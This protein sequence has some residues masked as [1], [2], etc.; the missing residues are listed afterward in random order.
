MVEVEVWLWWGGGE[1]L[2]MLLIDIENLTVL[3]DKQ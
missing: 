3:L 1:G 2:K